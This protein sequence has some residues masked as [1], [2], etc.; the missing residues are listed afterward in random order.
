MMVKV[1]FDPGLGHYEVF[2][3]A[4]FAH[5]TVYPGETTNSNLYG[6]NTDVAASEAATI[7]AGHRQRCWR[8]RR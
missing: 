3:I 1:A 2:G 7:A 8:L 6:G 5:E 4:G